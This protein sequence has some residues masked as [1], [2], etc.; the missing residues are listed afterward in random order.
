MGT[1]NFKSDLIEGEKGEFAVRDLLRRTYPKTYKREG[2]FKYYDLIIPEINKTVEVKYDFACARTGNYFI[3]TEFNKK[4]DYGNI[5][6]VECGIDCTQANYWCEI[7]DETIIIID[8]QA[9]RYFL[10]DFRIIT[11]PPKLT[12]LGGKGYLVP[13]QKLM[14]CPYAMVF[15]RSDKDIKVNL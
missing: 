1:Y 15:D 7:D 14:Y 5:I 3:E 2:Y 9:L 13:K 11:L 8:S 12:S 4:D 6:A 10:R